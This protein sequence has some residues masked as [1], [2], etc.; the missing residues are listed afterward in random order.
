MKQSRTIGSVLFLL[1]FVANA[2]ELQQKTLNAWQEYVRAANVRMQA[3]LHPRSHFLWVD[4]Q[5]ERR[6]RV[7][8]GEILVAPAG[9]HNPK[10]VP[11]GLIH[12]WVGAAFI[13][14]ATLG[15]VLAVV[16]N[17]ARYKDFYRPSVLDSKPIAQ[18]GVEDRFSMLLMNKALFSKT[19]LDGDY[20][21]SYFQVD[22]RRCYSIAHTTRVR[23]IQGYGG[24]GA[25]E[26]AENEG[27]GLIWRLSSITR[28]EERDGGVY[29]ELEAMALSRDIPVSLRWLVDPIVR[30]VSRESLTTSLQQTGSA[31]HNSEEMTISAE[32]HTPALP[33]RLNN[34]LLQ[35]QQSNIRYGAAT[36]RERF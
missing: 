2:A 23:E 22:D 30:R 34:P 18:A 6:V 5:P 14:N 3:R 31:V 16:R 24:P 35:G 11:S 21:S 13:P 8:N 26:L 12:D 32:R 20:E 10:R 36:A 27:S 29:V 17:Y 25:R 28:F 7:R 4:E 15:E 19:A 1:A 9:P 33:S